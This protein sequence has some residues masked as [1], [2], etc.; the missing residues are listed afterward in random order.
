MPRVLCLVL[1]S[2]IA[3]ALAAEQPAVPGSGGDQVRMETPTVPGSPASQ[4]ASHPASQP[5]RRPRTLP[6]QPQEYDELSTRAIELFKAAEPS[7]G[8]DGLSM[9]P[10]GDRLAW[11]ES[12]I[13]NAYLAMYEGTGDEHC[14]QTL[15][16]HIANVQANRAD[17][18]GLVDEIR[19]RTIAGWIS[20]GYSGDR[21]HAYLVHAGVLTYPMARLAYVLK[22]DP[23]RSMQYAA[24]INTLLA[25]VSQTIQSYESDWREGPGDDE[26]YYYCPI[27]KRDM[28][29]NQQN[30]LGR[31]IVA[32]YEATGQEWY[33]VR[34]AK[35]ARFF[36]DRLRRQDDRYLWDYWAHRPEFEDLSH[37]GFNVDFVVNCY[38]AGLVDSAGKRLFSNPD[39][40]RFVG[41]FQH[42]R[43]PDGGFAGRVDGSGHGG[44]LISIWGRLAGVD[45]AVRAAMGDYLLK[46]QDRSY[47]AMLLAG[48]LVEAQ[49][50]FEPESL[51]AS[52]PPAAG[53]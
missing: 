10:D 19:G 33:R 6:G 44:I 41:T 26:G 13:L 34:A 20:R 28:P 50:P 9:S 40:R 46:Q 51:P 1:A 42:I 23:Q 29:Y 49:R 43:T 30:A 27:L 22:Q 52:S 12:Y 15:L 16:R 45:P 5:A 36:K 14:L 4:A 38:R 25:D 8:P 39:M 35:L 3:T 32:M 47:F 11:G 53:N 37:A 18:R 21:A 24:Q 48:H 7:I 31:T 17:R 2:C